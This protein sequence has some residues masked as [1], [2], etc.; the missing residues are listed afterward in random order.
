MKFLASTLVPKHS[1][2]FAQQPL[3]QRA[4]FR[5]VVEL[6][7]WA[8]DIGY[9]AFGV[10]ERHNPALLSSSPAVILSH[11]AARTRRI[12]L[13][14]TVAVLSL[15]DPVRSAEDYATL[16]HLSDGRLDLIIGKGGD[17]VAPSVFRIDQAD[18]WDRLEEGYELVRRLWREE[19][20]HWQGRFRPPLSGAT[21]EPHPL[22]QPAPR[23]WHGSATSRRSTELAARWGDPL[24][25]ANGL[26]RDETYLDLV[27]HY[28]ERLAHH[29]HDA[30]A[31]VVAVGVHSPII[32]DRSQ[33]ALAIARPIFEASVR[34]HFSDR[35]RFPFDSLEDFVENGSA[36][37][38]T[39][40][41][42]T[43]KLLR[44][45]AKF[46]N[47]VFGVGVEG[48]FS[49]YTTDLAT[50]KGYLE[51]FFGE[52]APILRVEIPNT[53]WT[54]EPESGDLPITA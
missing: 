20:V 16:D 23:V 22:Q 13:V 11:I 18:L 27:R 30:D 44:T 31:A 10:G 17:A 34:E 12:R 53:L 26:G 48:F 37:V 8:E 6:A 39:A 5:E 33:D 29:G 7:R 1:T 3:S 9:D 21:I 15:T 46:G 38:G 41:Q 25:S 36:L 51:R 24:Y 45:H 14:T 19:D 28:R 4:R 2:G 35:S 40:E 52:V 43:E 47:Q 54:P 32:T 50:T 49:T 42:I